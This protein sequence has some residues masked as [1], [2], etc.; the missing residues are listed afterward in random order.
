MAHAI[1]GYQWRALV[2]SCREGFARALP[3]YAKCGESPHRGPR[4][5][6]ARA[7]VVLGYAGQSQ[8]KGGEEGLKKLVL[9]PETVA[10][11][12]DEILA[13]VYGGIMRAD[14]ADT[15]GC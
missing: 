4:G 2:V 5:F 3:Q 13:Q 10:A 8:S 12:D 1:G 7:G 9:K 6:L 15:A 14:T 11:L